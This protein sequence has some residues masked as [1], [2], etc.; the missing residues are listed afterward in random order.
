LFES[1]VLRKIFGRKRD[2]VTGGW[3]KLHKGALHDLYSSPDI[4]R[5]EVAGHVAR[6]GEKRTAYGLLV[7]R[8]RLL[9]RPRRRW[10]DKIKM[11]LIEIMRWCGLDWPFL[12]P[13]KIVSNSLFMYTPEVGCCVVFCDVG[14][15]TPAHC[16]R[17][18]RKLIQ[19]VFVLC[20]SDE[21]SRDGRCCQV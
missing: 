15:I 11:V 7:G 4:I 10:V 6:M 8:K 12:T 21:I 19:L 3:R 9:A 5:F 2:E 16:I 13:S 14:S 17:K 20:S 1:R 18:G